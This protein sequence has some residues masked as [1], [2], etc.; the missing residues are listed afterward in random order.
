MRDL[1]WIRDGP[2]EPACADAM[3]L[4]TFL[5]WRHVN[6]AKKLQHFVPIKS[7]IDLQTF[8]LIDTEVIWNITSEAV[9][10]AV[11]LMHPDHRSRLESRENP[12][13]DLCI[14]LFGHNGASLLSRPSTCVRELSD[15]QHYGRHHGALVAEVRKAELKWVRQPSPEKGLELDGSSIHW[16]AKEERLRKLPSASADDEIRVAAA[17]DAVIRVE[18]PRE[19]AAIA[20][21][22]LSRVD[23]RFS[24]PTTAKLEIAEAWQAEQQ[25]N[26]P[27]QVRLRSALMVNTIAELVGALDAQ[28]L[29]ALVNAT[30]AAFAVSVREQLLTLAVRCMNRAKD[31]NPD[32]HQSALEEVWSARHYLRDLGEGGLT[33]PKE[34]FLLEGVGYVGGVVVQ[35][36]IDYHGI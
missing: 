24:P 32:D 6:E 8:I 18:C 30:T 36:S 10:V 19:I 28:P 9:A 3:Y 33:G 2:A 11:N 29:P 13:Q 1:L 27:A 14:L 7:C 22:W 15:I 25:V 20:T 12:V 5:A 21:G 35:N 26:Y 34:D 23:V 31:L 17:A 16:I 4:A